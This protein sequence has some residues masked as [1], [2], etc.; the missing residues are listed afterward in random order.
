MESYLQGQDLQKIITGTETRPPPQDDPNIL[1]RWKLKTG[2]IIFA[3]KTTIEDEMMEHIREA[4]TL[5]EAQNLF[6]S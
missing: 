4:T 5:K 3:I 2:K 6:A 1:K